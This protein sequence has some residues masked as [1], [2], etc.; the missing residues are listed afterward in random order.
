MVKVLVARDEGVHILLCKDGSCRVVV[1]T[2]ILHLGM[3]ADKKIGTMAVHEKEAGS[4]TT[5]GVGLTAMPMIVIMK[6]KRVCSCSFGGP[7]NVSV[8]DGLE[9][10]Q[11]GQHGAAVFVLFH[12]SSRLVRLLN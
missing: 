10:V 2:G 3:W 8:C 11:P 12:K 7:A 1:D 6:V 4:D 9:T 5:S